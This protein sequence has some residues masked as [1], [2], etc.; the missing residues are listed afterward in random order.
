MTTQN[1]IL[2]IPEALYH[3]IKQRAQH[4]NRSVEDETLELLASA[5]PAK[6]ILPEELTNVVAPLGLLD[7]DSL[8]RAARSHLAAE[9]ASELETLHMKRQREG[10]TSSEQQTLAALMRQYERALLIRARAAA[11]LHERGFDV[12]ELNAPFGLNAARGA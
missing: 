12:R 4:S 10:L 5:V 7:N 8:W 11:L 2:S 1:L 6:D 9:A 3:Q